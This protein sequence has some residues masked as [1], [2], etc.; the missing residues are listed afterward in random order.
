MKEHF[1]NNKHTFEATINEN[2]FGTTIKIGGKT[3]NDCINISINKSD[4]TRAIIPH[5]QSEPECSF[6]KILEEKETSDFIKVSLQYVC[7]KFPTVKVFKFDDMSKIDCGKKTLDIPPEFRKLNKPFSLAHLY[8]A[9]HGETWYENRFG[10]K[11]IN[12]KF[13]QVYK[14]AVKKLHEKITIDYDV[15][16]TMNH[17]NSA[18]DAILSKYYSND[19]TYIEFFNS[20]PKS[21]RCTA[22]YNWLPFF[23][24]PLLEY[25]YISTG[26]YIDIA[27]M[28]KTNMEIISP[29][30]GGGGKRKHNHNH[31][32]NRNTRRA[33]RGLLFTNK[34][35]LL[36]GSGNG[37]IF[38]GL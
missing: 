38:D 25:S 35:R 37:Y 16:K 29:P 14:D 5:I 32:H 17:I 26:W 34:K 15:F 20:I 8:L 3:F 31:N 33:P 21:D 19:K 28:P 12:P 24:D 18:Q 11:M 30:T 6:D 2:Q 10:A 9:F 13:Y 36:D 27:T 1:K 7:Q 22:L 4:L 23:I